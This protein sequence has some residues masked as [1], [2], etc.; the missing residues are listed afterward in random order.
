MPLKPLQSPDNG[1]ARFRLHASAAK[2]QRF[3]V[4]L[5]TSLDKA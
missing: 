1:N 3:D 5:D 4:S 2:M